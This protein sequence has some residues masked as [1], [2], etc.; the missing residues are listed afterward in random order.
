MKHGQHIGHLYALH[1]SSGASSCV[2]QVHRIVLVKPAMRYIIEL[3]VDIKLWVK[4]RNEIIS[5]ILLS[6]LHS[7]LISSPPPSSFAVELNGYRGCDKNR[8]SGSGVPT[9][10]LVN[11]R[12]KAE[13]KSARMNDFITWRGD[14]YAYAPKTIWWWPWWNIPSQQQNHKSINPGQ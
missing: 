3:R 10:E 12:S 2:K 11:W 7:Y 14:S 9:G 13:K 5:R 8:I 6:S 4:R 1:L